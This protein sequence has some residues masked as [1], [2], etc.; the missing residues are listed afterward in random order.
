LLDL[1]GIGTDDVEAFLR[2]AGDVFVVHRGHD[3]KNTSAGVA[4]GH[5]RWFVKWA[6]DPEAI[7]HL[8]SA[9][10]FHAAVRHPA[11]VTVRGWFTLPSGLALVHDWVPGEVLN[12]PLV[13]GGLPRDDPR[14]AFARFRRLGVAEALAAFSVVLDAHLVVAERGFV[15]V[16]FYDG[17]LIY[18]FGR[19]A[20]RLCDLDSYRP[21]PYTLDRDR[22]YGSSRFMAPEEFRRGATIDERSTVFNLGRAA[23]VLVGGAVRGEQDRHLWRASD[24]LYQVASTATCP[25]PAGRYQSVGDLVLAWRAALG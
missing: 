7:G 18:D 16:D 24:A 11:I 22:Q 23:F 25:D 6:T 19:R 3:S 21:G 17:C 9:V 12:D 4:A 5:R 13:P 8:E 2:R 1:T 20:I 10:R 14:S 15:A